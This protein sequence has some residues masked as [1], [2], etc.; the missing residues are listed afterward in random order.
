MKTTL[1]SLAIFS[2]LFAGAAMAQSYGIGAYHS[3]TF[4]EA[5]SVMT[6]VINSSTVDYSLRELAPVGGAGHDLYK[7]EISDNNGNTY[8]Y[9]IGPDGWVSNP[10]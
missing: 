5:E 9:L 4:Q 3:M 6:E 2:T 1:L 10:K 7:A 8:L